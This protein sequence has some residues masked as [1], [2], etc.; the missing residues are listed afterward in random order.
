MP[1]N[2]FSTVPPNS[3]RIVPVSPRPPEP[4]FRGLLLAGPDR[5]VLIS[6][7]RSGPLS[8][9]PHRLVVCASI[10]Y[11][12]LDRRRFS[13]DGNA[14]PLAGLCVTV[15]EPRLGFAA[16]GRMPRMPIISRQPNDPAVSD[17]EA[18]R[19]VMTSYINP[20]LPDVVPMPAKAGRYHV[21]LDWGPWCSP[22]ITIVVSLPE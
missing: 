9:S 5:A 2:P 18:E 3:M 16:T 22:V 14:D 12:L 7:G 10:T 13:A 11:S 21:H 6:P 4:T 1:D 15:S 17:A 20:N 19:F 8:T